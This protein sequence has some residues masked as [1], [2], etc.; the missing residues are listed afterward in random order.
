MKIRD[1]IERPGRFGPEWIAYD[2][3]KRLAKVLNHCRTRVEKE[4]IPNQ[5]NWI[6]N[7]QNEKWI[8]AM[9]PESWFM[10]LGPNSKLKK[11][12]SARLVQSTRDLCDDI[13]NCES[14]TLRRIDYGTLRAPGTLLIPDP[15]TTLEKSEAD[16]PEETMR[17]MRSDR[18]CDFDQDF[19]KG[20]IEDTT[21]NLKHLLNNHRWTQHEIEDEA[22][23]RIDPILHILDEMWCSAGAHGLRSCFLSIALVFIYGTTGLFLP[24][25]SITLRALR[26]CIQLRLRP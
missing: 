7:L 20:A 13:S 1:E 25:I 6:Q 16:L 22:F 4:S 21:V 19:V 2:I 26:K 10:N 9:S 3:F 17:Q 8:D 14:R 11:S 5:I 18:D 15:A 12:L 24:W 23:V